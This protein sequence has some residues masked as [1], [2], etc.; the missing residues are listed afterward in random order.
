MILTEI[1]ELLC[2]TER[3][4]FEIALTF[5]SNEVGREWLAVDRTLEVAFLG[6]M[7][8]SHLR[9]WVYSDKGM[10]HVSDIGGTV[11]YEGALNDP[12]CFRLAARAVDS[13]M[14]LKPY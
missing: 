10:I 6:S 9:I 12:D 13:C 3:P 1:H 14:R 4:P 7:Y 8:P 2:T 11:L 5:K